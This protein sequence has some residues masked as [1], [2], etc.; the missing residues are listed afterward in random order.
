MKLVQGKGSAGGLAQ[1][2]IQAKNLNERRKF[3]GRK[4]ELTGVG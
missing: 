4:L 2:R 3:F 1:R